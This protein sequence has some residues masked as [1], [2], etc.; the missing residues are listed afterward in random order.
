MIKMNQ[1]RNDHEM[2]LLIRV[3]SMVET[4][5]E[6]EKEI[7]KEIV[8]TEIKLADVTEA[9]VVIAPEK[10]VATDH[11]IND[12]TN[13]DLAKKEKFQA[14]VV[15]HFIERLFTLKIPKL[16]QKLLL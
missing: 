9:E 7:V 6:N 1:K 8:E 15:K 13:I 12:V 5:I 16:Q 14:N 4:K 3:R 2:Q 10:I 11:R